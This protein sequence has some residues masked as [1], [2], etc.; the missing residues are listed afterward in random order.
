ML[1][2]Y[3]QTDL[4]TGH[5]T[6]SQSALFKFTDVTLLPA[7]LRFSAGVIEWLASDLTDRRQTVRDGRV[8]LTAWFMDKTIYFSM[9]LKP[10]LLFLVIS[11]SQLDV[12]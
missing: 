3:G 2:V 8:F 4:K 12:G 6:H 5:C 9:L 1:F 7:K 11:L 10:N